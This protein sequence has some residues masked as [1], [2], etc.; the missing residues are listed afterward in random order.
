MIII[1]VVGMI[2]GHSVYPTENYY[3][4]TTSYT[5]TSFSTL[6]STIS[7]Q[8]IV[9][10]RYSSTQ[11]QSFI[12]TQFIT[13]TEIVL[14][15]PNNITVIFAPNPIGLQYTYDICCVDPSISGISNQSASFNLP[16]LFKGQQI[17]ITANL[18]PQCQ[19]NGYPC[20]QVH[21]MLFLDN[22]MVAQTMADSA[23][24]W[25]MGILTAKMTYVV[26]G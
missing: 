15:I 3:T 25:P 16:N 7:Y 6:V 14:P 5:N 22:V 10:E 24:N 8:Y 20:G 4:T 23:A 9:T 2:A 18:F 1:G 17:T 12:I 11:I 13:T 19:N 21:I 26:G